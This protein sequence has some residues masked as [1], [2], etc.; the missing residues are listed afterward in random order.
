ML[1]TLTLCP[2][3]RTPTHAFIFSFAFT[4]T[5]LIT[6]TGDAR[7]N[8]RG[9]VNSLNRGHMELATQKHG[10][11]EAAYNFTGVSLFPKPLHVI[12]AAN[13]PCSGLLT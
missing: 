13:K 1:Q 9:V 7:G 3:T 2:H 11:E 8:V 5:C 4:Y 10:V 12:Y 6:R